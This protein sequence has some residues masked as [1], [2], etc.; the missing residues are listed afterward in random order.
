MQLSAYR[1]KQLSETFPE[2]HF[3]TGERGQW[4]QAPGWQPIRELVERLLV[5]YDWHEA[6]VGTQL[7]LKPVTD[8]LTL[9]EFASA[10]RANGDDLDALI[11]DNLYKDSERSQRWTTACTRY[12][13]S[14]GD[15]NRAALLETLARWRALGEAAIA[16][17]AELL[18]PYAG[19]DAV[20]SHVR[21]GWAGLLAEAGLGTDA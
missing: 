11:S 16:G 13:I 14:A 2:R 15:G 3:G 17:G 10:A 8:L 6:F 7:V 18:A 19:R 20:A 5:A 4:E 1:A 21:Q 9:H 12:L